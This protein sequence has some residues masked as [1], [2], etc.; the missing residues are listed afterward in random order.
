MVFFSV[1]RFYYTLDISIW[2]LIILY[3]LTWNEQNEDGTKMLEDTVI[4]MSPSFKA[5]PIRQ[6][7]ASGCVGCFC[8]LLTYSYLSSTY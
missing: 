5:F 1:L 3:Y 2:F 7:C 4:N 6:N 8:T